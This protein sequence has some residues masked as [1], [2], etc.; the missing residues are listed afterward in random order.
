MLDFNIILWYYFDVM[1]AVMC[2]VAD[3]PG[4]VVSVNRVFVRSKSILDIGEG[5]MD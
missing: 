1:T 4:V 2:E 5:R 3:T